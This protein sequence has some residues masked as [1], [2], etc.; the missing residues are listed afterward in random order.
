MES[1]S[2]GNVNTSFD[3]NTEMSYNPTNNTNNNNN[4]DQLDNLSNLI[5]NNSSTTNANNNSSSLSNLSSI[6]CA[7]AEDENILLEQY[8]RDLDK[9]LNDNLLNEKEQCYQR[10][11]QS[12]QTSA[13][14]V[15][16]M[17]KDKT[18]TTT[19][20]ATAVPPAAAAN[21]ISNH[22]QQLTPWE[23]FQNSA[24]AIT[25]LYKGKHFRL[26]D[27]LFASNQI[28]INHIF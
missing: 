27:F 18:S 1:H 13:C 28:F 14:T 11:F 20:A 24:G 21:S 8:E 23:S 3:T 2:V 22:P 4:S 15:A 12:F 6:H 9:G 10:L 25:V 16:Q 19:T 17:F 7:S 5:I 26:A